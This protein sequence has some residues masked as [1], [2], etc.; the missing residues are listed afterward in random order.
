MLEQKISKS[1]P[2]DPSKVSNG[3]LVYCL[4]TDKERILLQIG[5]KTSKK[6]DCEQAA[7]TIRQGALNPNVF[8]FL[9]ISETP[10]EK[11]SLKDKINEKPLFHDQTLS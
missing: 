7:I 4:T 11:K 5:K 10:K 3:N 6:L 8:V 9:A 2:P 1:Y